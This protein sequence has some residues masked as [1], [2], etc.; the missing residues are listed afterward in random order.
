VTSASGTKRTCL[1]ESCV[2]LL[3]LRTNR[4]RARDGVPQPANGTVSQADE[5]KV[6]GGLPFCVPARTDPLGGEGAVED[7]AY[8]LIAD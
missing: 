2:R 4:G 8:A 5:F 6:R 1:A 7:G 3:G